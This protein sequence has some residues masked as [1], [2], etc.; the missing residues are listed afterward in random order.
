MLT[1]FSFKSL[2]MSHTGTTC[3]WA[4]DWLLLIGL[5]SAPS[6]A[7]PSLPCSPWTLGRPP[8][9]QW[10][11]TTELWWGVQCKSHTP[12]IYL[13]LKKKSPVCD[14]RHV[15]KRN[16][17]VLSW[18]L[19]PRW[20]STG[21][22][23][24]SGRGEADGHRTTQSVGASFPSLYS[25]NLMGIVTGMTTAPTTHG[26]TPEKWTSESLR[27]R[28]SGGYT[29][30]HRGA[31]SLWSSRS[32]LGSCGWQGLEVVGSTSHLSYS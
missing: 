17:Q 29:V 32:Y 21:C 9:H 4:L 7:F 24:C 3:R 30:R 23:N 18:L 28:A 27:A 14:S 1:L 8:I 15:C 22:A 2:K 13:M 12:H 26:G 20:S 31:L 11:V 6:L 5:W 25:N 10:N 19:L 16:M